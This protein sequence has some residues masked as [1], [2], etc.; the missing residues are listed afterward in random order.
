[1]PP[2]HPSPVRRALSRFRRHLP[3]ALFAFCLLNWLFAV[4][5]QGRWW[6]QIC[7]HEHHYADHITLFYGLY[8]A[9]GYLILAAPAGRGMFAGLRPPDLA[10]RPVINRYNGPR[11]GASILTHPAL[12]SPADPIDWYQEVRYRGHGLARQGFVALWNPAPPVPQRGLAIHWSLL[13]VATAALAAIQLLLAL[14]RRPRPTNSQPL[15]PTCGYDCRATPTRCPECGTP[16]TRLNDPL[17]S[18]SNPP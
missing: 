9:R 2:P 13:T 3:P 6:L 4:P 1:M 18:T 15:C 12:H 8:S 5:L 17:P 11:V 14:R 16:F 10:T 7:S